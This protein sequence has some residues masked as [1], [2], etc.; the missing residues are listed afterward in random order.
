MLVLRECDGDDLQ[1]TFFAFHKAE[2]EQK[3]QVGTS[4]IGLG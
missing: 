1:E 2:E 3:D 4:M